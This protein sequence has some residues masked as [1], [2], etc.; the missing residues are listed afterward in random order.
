MA[1]Y[2][3]VEKGKVINVSVWDGDTE[4]WAPSEGQEAVLIPDGLPVTTGT[5]CKK[6]VFTL[7]PIAQAPEL[8]PSAEDI[9]KK[10]TN[11]RDTA[12]A[13]ATLAIGPLQD[14]VDLDEA[15]AEETGLLKKWK[16]YRI[17]V[18][19]IDL[20]LTSPPWPEQPA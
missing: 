3:I 1:N 6:G 10:N 12:L 8:V 14:A 2:A 4:N 13:T 19:R 5:K 15:T 9:L 11:L 7:E 20:T 17:A 16:Q 18:N